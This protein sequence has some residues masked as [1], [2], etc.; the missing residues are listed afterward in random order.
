MPHPRINVPPDGVFDPRSYTEKALA[1]LVKAKARAQRAAARAQ[2]AAD[3]SAPETLSGLESPATGA[4]E[5]RPSVSAA[6][7]T[8][9]VGAASSTN[10][11]DE[12]LSASTRSRN[13]DADEALERRLNLLKEH[14]ALVRRFVGL[15]IPVLVDVYAATVALKVRTKVLTAL[16]KTVGY[17]VPEEL[18]EVL[19]VRRP[20]ARAVRLDPEPE[21]DPSRA[22]TRRSP[23]PAFSAPSCRRAT[24]RP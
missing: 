6:N 21:T 2:A 9:D 3:P 15:I 14:P 16:L 4:V 1:R 5:D 24:T 13:K 12:A 23:L 8:D 20:F 10:V 18:R 19:Q 17:L 7:S 11:V 22:P